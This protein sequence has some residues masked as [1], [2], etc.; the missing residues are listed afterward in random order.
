[1]PSSMKFFDCFKSSPAVRTTEVVPSPTSLS[2]DLAISTN[3]FAAGWTI[4][5][6]PIRVAPSFEMVT[7]LP[8]WISLSIP[9]GP[10]VV[11]TTSTID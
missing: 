6:N 11:L 9:L 4:S 3:V 5:S 10:R 8:S 7:L 2:Y 1:M